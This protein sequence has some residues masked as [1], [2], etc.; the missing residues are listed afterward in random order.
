MSGHHRLHHK[1]RCLAESEDT[2]GSVVLR[3]ICRRR[4]VMA[5]LPGSRPVEYYAEAT[6]ALDIA[7][8]AGSV[9]QL[10]GDGE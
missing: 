7:A 3:C 5:D 4:Q 10:Y 2:S 6:K 9:S 1:P 8:H